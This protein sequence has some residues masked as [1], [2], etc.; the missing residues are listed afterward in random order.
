H[1]GVLI[2]NAQGKAVGFAL[3]NLQGRGQMMVDPG[4]PVYEG[5]VVGIHSRENDLTV[6]PLKAKQLTNVRA[7]GTDENIVLTPPVRMSL[8]PALEFPHAD[9]SVGRTRNSIRMR[10]RWRTA[11][12]RKK[13]S[14]APASA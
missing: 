11:H 3:F 4:E 1:N 8:D 13:A 12:E 2:A 10:E 14:R 7:A 5:M 9:A 6:N